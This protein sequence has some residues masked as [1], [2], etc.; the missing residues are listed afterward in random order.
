MQ[1]IQSKFGNLLGF[2]SF[3]ILLVTQWLHSP[4]HHVVEEINSGCC[5]LE[6]HAS[7][8]HS[9]SH[10]KAS[11]PHSHSAGDPQGHDEAQ[12]GTDSGSPC[13]HPHPHPDENCQ[14]CSFLALNPC[15]LNLE[16]ELV[17]HLF[18]DV[19]PDS[20]AV[21]VISVRTDHWLI[22]GPPIA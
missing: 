1:P 7:A 13:H 19:I 12:A 10:H 5:A 21:V 11:H 20:A 3:A 9:H 18:V 22:R 15:Q 14:I 4:L 6:T 17:G 2:A 16:V 8:G